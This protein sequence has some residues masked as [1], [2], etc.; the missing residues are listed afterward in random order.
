MISCLLVKI[1]KSNYAQ[2]YSTKP[3]QLKWGGS[4]NL[5]QLAEVIQPNSFILDEVSQETRIIIS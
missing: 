1:L 5:N 4:K 2:L 3:N